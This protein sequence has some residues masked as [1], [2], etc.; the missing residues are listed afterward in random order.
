MIATWKQLL[1]PECRVW[2]RLWAL[3]L[4]EI[5][6]VGCW[7]SILP[8]LSPTCQEEEKEE[9][10]PLGENYLQS[11]KGKAFSENMRCESSK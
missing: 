6:T 5:L 10:A 11:F 1:A 2:C 4:Q 3:R 7:Q 9:P 8:Q